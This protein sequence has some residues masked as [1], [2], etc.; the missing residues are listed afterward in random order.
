[1]RGVSTWRA[2]SATRRSPGPIGLVASIRTH[3]VST[4]AS[5]ERATA[6]V[7]SPRSVRGLCTPGVSRNT[8]CESGVVRTPRMAARVVWGRS[9]TMA[10]FWPTSRLSS[11]DLPTLGRPTSVTNPERKLTVAEAAAPP[12]AGAGARARE[13]D[14]TWRS[15]KGRRVRDFA[16]LLRFFLGFG[17]RASNDDR[18]D[19][20]ALHA[21]GTELEVLEAHALGFDGNVP[22][23]VEHEATHRGPFGVG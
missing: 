4:S 3:T 12:T 20:T 1:M 23:Q 2:S 13:G 15:G 16:R 21:F 7:R 11:V 17:L 14:R 22:E 8:I 10:T 6:L 18:H 9:E 5:A 19:P